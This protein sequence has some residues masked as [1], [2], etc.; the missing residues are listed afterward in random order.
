[1]FNLTHYDLEIK[2]TDS[3]AMVARIGAKFNLSPDLKGFLEELLK[4][5]RAEWG[6][7]IWKIFDENSEK[8]ILKVQKWFLSFTFRVKHC[9]PVIRFLIG[10]RPL[11]I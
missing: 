7:D 3:D 9:E 6:D 10:P 1:M 5:G 4:V 2:G 8:K 11:P